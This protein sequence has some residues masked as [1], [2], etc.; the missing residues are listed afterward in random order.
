MDTFELALQSLLDAYPNTNVTSALQPVSSS[1]FD[2][3]KH[4]HLSRSALGGAIGVITT[5]ENRVVLVERNTMHA[6][7]ALPGGT[8]EQNEDFTEA[9]L[10]EIHEEIGIDLIDVRLR[11]IEIK[12]FL[13]PDDESLRFAL[14]VFGAKTEISVLPEATA[15][16][17]AEG[18]NASLF[19]IDRLPDK[20]ILGDR[21]KTTAYAGK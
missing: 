16:A 6:G 15:E 1:D 4:K 5:P 10:R 9:F 3:Q 11:E 19:P 12:T 13:S 18:V 2:A 7:W 8:V 17:V 21:H 14:A 20:I